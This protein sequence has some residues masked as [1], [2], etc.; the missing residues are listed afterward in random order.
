MIDAWT[1]AYNRGDHDGALA[2]LREYTQLYPKDP[3][4]YIFASYT[5]VA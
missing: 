1:A 4:G 2:S 3:T 5:Y